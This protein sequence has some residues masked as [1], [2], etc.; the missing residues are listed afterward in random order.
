MDEHVLPP[1]IEQQ[2]GQNRI[3]MLYLMTRGAL[4]DTIIMKMFNDDEAAT[5]P[6]S[7][8]VPP[9]LD[10]VSPSLRSTGIQ[11]KTFIASSI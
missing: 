9:R 3:F 2:I 4:I 5:P 11:Y 8:L 1:I 10:S 6:P 7:Q